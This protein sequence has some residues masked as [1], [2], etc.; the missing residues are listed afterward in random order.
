MALQ[1]L[2]LP[3]SKAFAEWTVWE[4]GRFWSARDT[5]PVRSRAADVPAAVRALRHSPDGVA[6]EKR[7]FIVS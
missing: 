3:L 5:P 2:A 7:D 4:M 6:A 1:R